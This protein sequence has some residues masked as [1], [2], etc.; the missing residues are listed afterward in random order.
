MNISDFWSPFETEITSF[1][2]LVKVIDGVMKKAIKSKIVFAW[3]GQVDARWALH[4]SLFR[5]YRL[6]R[7]VDFTET[8]FEKQEEKILADLHR[9]GLHS[10]VQSGRLS[11]L[12]Q[13]AMLQH[14]GAPTRLVDVSFNAWIG[15]FFAVEE[16]IDNGNVILEDVD[17]RLFAIDVSGRLINE[18]SDLRDWEDEIHRPWRPRA[19]K[20]LNENEWTTSVY[21]WRPPNLD[22]RISAQNGG[23][24]FGGVAG[25]IK[26]NG[27]RFQFP[28]GLTGGAW[29]IS[30]GR[31][32][33]CLALRP[34]KYGAIKGGVT[35]GALY[36]F[37]IKADAKKE[38]RDKLAKMFGYRHSTVYPDYSGFA[39][40]GTPWL[41]QR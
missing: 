29:K 14:F 9:W 20:K 35:A 15:V 41:K 22:N 27:N 31:E 40:Y 23:F 12:K 32:A 25:S 19:A 10:P 39:L 26:P 11:V 8:D 33:C 17:S 30:E 6:T 1:D 24:L 21:A 3:R 2:D 7:G 34:H 36:T 28:N 37:R 16:K 4:S 18:N 5:R 13:L 38:I